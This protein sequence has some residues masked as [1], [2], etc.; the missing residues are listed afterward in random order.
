MPGGRP[1]KYGPKLIE[2][3]QEYLDAGKK[4]DEQAIPTIAGLALHIGVAR[5]TCQLWATDPET[6]Q[7]YHI[8]RH[9]MAAQHLLLY[10]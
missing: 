7:F 6:A 4:D 3:A 5:E 2:K 10:K 8:H 9:R 1:P